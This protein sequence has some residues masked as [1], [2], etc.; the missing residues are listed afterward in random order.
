M[1]SFWKEIQLRP[2]FENILLLR[3]DSY[4]LQLLIRDILSVESIKKVF[5][6]ATKIINHFNTAPLRLA[7]LQD[8]QMTQYQ[9]EYALL[10]S[11]IMLLGIPILDANKSQIVYRGIANLWQKDAS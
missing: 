2:G 8:I 3:C 9:K 7:I 4:G 5:T 11:V 6:K 1:Q 10:G